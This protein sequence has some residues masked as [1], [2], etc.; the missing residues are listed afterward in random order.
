[1]KGSV[2]METRGRKKLPEGLKR[3]IHIKFKFNKFERE[4]F[5]SLASEC[6]AILNEKSNS[7]L[8]LE[9]LE[10]LLKKIKK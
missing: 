8:I 10:T 9:A 4:R 1:M 7:T 6:K 2:N 5:D 3:D